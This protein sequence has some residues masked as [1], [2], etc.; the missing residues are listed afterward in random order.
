MSNISY[1]NSGNKKAIV[2]GHFCLDILPDL[3]NVPFKQFFELFQ[4][5]HLLETGKMNIAT[6]GAASNTG[7][8]LNKLGLSASIIARLGSDG[9]GHIAAEHLENFV[10]PE[11]NCLNLVEGETTSY[12][13]IVNPPGID[14]IFLH[15]PGA[16]DSFT[17]T[18]VEF[19]KFPEH[20]LFHFG[21]PQL[22]KSMY[23]DQGKRLVALFQKAKNAGFTTSLDTT[24]PDPSSPMG[25]VNWEDVLRA[26]LPYVDIFSPSYEEAY[27][28]LDKQGYQ[29]FIDSGV[30][31]AP[32]K[33]LMDLT[34]RILDFGAKIAFLKLGSSG[35]ILHVSD[36]LDQ[37]GFGK[38][39]F[40]GLKQ[41][42][43]RTLWAPSYQVDVVGTTGA[44]DATIAGL[45]GAVMREMPIETALSFAMGVGACNVEAIDSVSGVRTWAETMTRI[46]DGWQKNPMGLP[47][48]AW[49]WSENHQIWEWRK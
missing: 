25:K 17:D 41:W 4:P 14:R 40:P 7:I 28:M 2:A 26:V 46:N 1:H 48:P 49:V 27:F 16:N 34:E 18:D 29:S 45:L 47:S 21:Y 9:F 23:M 6:G 13:I 22:M 8:S 24:F 15:H 44:G 42:E 39:W 19:S 37:Q 36:Q 33:V 30:E 11:F 20:V 32:D 35:A 3:S 38:A 12:T 10:A 5:G 43:A 31:L